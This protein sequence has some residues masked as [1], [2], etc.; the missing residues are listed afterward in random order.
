MSQEVGPL[1]PGSEDPDAVAQKLLSQFSS[2]K[3]QRI[4]ESNEP[5]NGGGLEESPQSETHE[6]SPSSF[7]VV[8]PIVANTNDYNY[9]P[10]HFAVRRILKMN[11]DNPRKPLY[12]V[13]LQSGERETVICCCSHSKLV[14]FSDF[15]ACF[16]D[17][18]RSIPA[19]RKQPRSP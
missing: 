6:S 18:H 15:I 19:T 5:R 4:S 10:G 13:R 8:V 7:E 17:D 2:L 16:T 11:S 9:L 3:A 14:L 12:T 1:S